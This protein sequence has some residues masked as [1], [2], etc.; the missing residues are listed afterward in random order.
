MLSISINNKQKN[1]TDY[2]P[3]LGQEAHYLNVQNC[4]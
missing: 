4:I 3:N 1:I 2:K